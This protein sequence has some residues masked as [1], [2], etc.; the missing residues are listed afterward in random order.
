MEQLYTPSRPPFVEKA[1][2]WSSSNGDT[3]WATK[4]NYHVQDDRESPRGWGEI[5]CIQGDQLRNTTVQEVASD[6]QRRPGRVPALSSSQGNDPVMPLA[7]ETSLYELSDQELLSIAA[8]VGGDP[9]LRLAVMDF[10]ASFGLVGIGEHVLRAFRSEA[11][12]DFRNGLVLVAERFVRETGIRESS[13][14]A[15]FTAVLDTPSDWSE[16]ALASAG[17]GLLHQDATRTQPIT[18]LL[19][20][21]R[22]SDDLLVS[23]LANFPIHF[24]RSGLPAEVST[25]GL[26]TSLATKF[27]DPVIFC[28]GPGFNA[29]VGGAAFTALATLELDEA[30]GVLSS[31]GRQIPT[32]ARPQLL[33]SLQESSKRM[34]AARGPTEARAAY[35]ERVIRSARSPA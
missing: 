4:A 11:G 26:L 3:S 32:W 1:P 19:L 23:A 22:D 16:R 15:L 28:A 12:A 2:T 9:E 21:R 8:D 34:T 5:R 33:L 30:L 18:E 20:S 10:A 29:A 17:R 7:S 6:F 25:L 31:L 27:C 14:A 24:A 35:W 13:W